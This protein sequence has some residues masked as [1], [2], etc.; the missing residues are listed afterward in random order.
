M[1]ALRRCLRHAAGVA[2]GR[3]RFSHSDRGSALIEF[4]FVA[5][6]VLVPLLYLV[7]SVAAVGQARLAV[8]AAA[9]E[10][11]RAI[12][13]TPTGDDPDARALAALTISLRPAH[14]SAAEVTLRYVEATE[15]CSTTGADVVP[16]LTPGLTFA[17]CVARHQGVPGVPSVLNGRGVTLIG[18]YVVQIDRYRE[19]GPTG[20][21]SSVLPATPGTPAGP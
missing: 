14:L 21:G 11:G 4:T 7:V 2:R 10:V 16:V 19:T 18:R 1:N 20:P 9:R 15:A 5:V 17:V 3:I 12:Q 6:L 8:T 13:T